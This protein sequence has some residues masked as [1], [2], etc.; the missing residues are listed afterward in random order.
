[1]CAVA[2]AEGYNVFE[3]TF[4]LKLL[5]HVRNIA[6][7]SKIANTFLCGRLNIK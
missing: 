1:M 5:F 4:K 7:T 6:V 3:T 2:K